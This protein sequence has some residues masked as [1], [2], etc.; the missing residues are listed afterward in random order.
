MN[1]QG[2][3]RGHLLVGP[4]TPGGPKHLFMV[5]RTHK[6]SVT[7][8]GHLGDCTAEINLKTHGLYKEE[9]EWKKVKYVEEP[10]RGSGDF[11]GVMVDA[12]Y[13]REHGG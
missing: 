11:G 13:M 3:E 1:V 9:S 4:L 6:Y 5:T 12:S 8:V 2:L 10:K 7:A